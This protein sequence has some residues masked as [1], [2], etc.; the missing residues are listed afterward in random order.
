MEDAL[1]EPLSVD[2]G[3]NVGD[4]EGDS[5]AVA[6]TDEDGDVEKEAEADA[7]AEGDA[8]EVVVGE[9][10]AE[11]VTVPEGEKLNEDVDD[12]LYVLLWLKDTD[13]VGDAEKEALDVVHTETVGEPGSDGAEDAVSVTVPE[14]EKEK[15]EV[16]D[17]LSVELWLYDEDT[18]GDAEKEPLTVGHVVDEMDAEYVGDNEAVMETVPLGEKE[19]EDVLEAEKDPL[20]EKEPDAVKDVVTVPLGD[21]V[22]RGDAESEGDVECVGESVGDSVGEK[23]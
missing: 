15:L 16:D 10:E 21:T 13:T 11:S 7:Q 4:A 8:E 19:K 2:I 1:K 22:P 18:V 9:R 20:C 6:Q 3:E 23:E 5:D 17:A 14:G 12:A